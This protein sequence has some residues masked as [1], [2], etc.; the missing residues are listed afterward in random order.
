M[1]PFASSASGSIAVSEASGSA[2][3]NG[4]FLRMSASKDHACE[5]RRRRLAGGLACL[6]GLLVYFF[7]LG[8]RRA[9]EVPLGLF[10]AQ[11]SFAAGF[12]VMWRAG[13][14]FASAGVAKAP[15]PLRSGNPVC[16]GKGRDWGGLVAVLFLGMAGCQGFTQEQL[17]GAP[18]YN[19][20]LL[21]SYVCALGLWLPGSLSR[22][23]YELDVDS[24]RVFEHRM[25]LGLRRTRPVTEGPIRFVAVARTAAL[26]YEV[27]AVTRNGTEAVPLGCRTPTEEQALFHASR[28]ADTLMVPLLERYRNQSIEVVAATLQREGEGVFPFRKDWERM[29]AP[30]ELESSRSVLPPLP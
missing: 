8:P 5:F 25:L 18:E 4:E 3:G 13:D 26:E 17:P 11:V 28:L 16:P 24:L 20:A 27:Y 23:W 30:L 22:C 15:R 29:A 19:Q 21:F 14:A 6:T 2:E 1:P 9:W 10:W 7:L 12:A